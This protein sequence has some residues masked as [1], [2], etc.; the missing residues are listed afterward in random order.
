MR[1][2]VLAALV[3]ALA[4]PALAQSDFPEPPH[5]G[6]GP[7]PGGAMPMPPQRQTLADMKTRLGEMFDRTDANH[8]GVIDAA[9]LANAR[10][11]RMLSRADANG[12]GRITREEALAGAE[13]MFKA[14]DKNGDGVITPDERPARPH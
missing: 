10:G 2:L 12:D 6:F 11:G 5:P 8:D 9:E 13:A 3:C 7:P 4:S 1:P 14:M